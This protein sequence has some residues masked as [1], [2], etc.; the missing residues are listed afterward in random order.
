MSGR[1]GRPTTTGKSRNKRSNTYSSTRGSESVTKKVKISNKTIQSFFKSSQREVE[2][3]IVELS[4]SLHTDTQIIEND[5]IECTETDDRYE[6]AST[7]LDI[8]TDEPISSPSSVQDEEEQH[9][10]QKDIVKTFDG[11]KQQG[12]SFTSKW[13]K[14]F[15]WAYYSSNKVGW[16]CKTCEEYSDTGDQYWKTL[17]R[18]H[19]EHPYLFFT[20]HVKSSKHIQSVKNKQEVKEI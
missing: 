5:S 19:D 6:S 1:R 16:F 3:N 11:R 8:L 14:Q 2:Q 20:E 7:E 4:D 9:T 18:K 17:P 15:L 10:S 13:E 12:L